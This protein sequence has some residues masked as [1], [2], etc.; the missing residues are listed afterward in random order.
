VL[1]RIQLMDALAIHES[2]SPESA[3]AHCSFGLEGAL[4]GGSLGRESSHLPRRRRRARYGRFGEAA[5]HTR[6]R[7]Q[8]VGSSSRSDSRLACSTVGGRNASLRDCV[9]PNECW[10]AMAMR[11]RIAV[12]HDHASCKPRAAVSAPSTTLPVL[13]RPGSRIA[14]AENPPLGHVRRHRRHPS[15]PASRHPY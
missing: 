15:T 5:E 12:S 4:C 6:G 11:H 3:T 7:R 1:A 8:A 13:V 10:F 14:S 2:T 9:A